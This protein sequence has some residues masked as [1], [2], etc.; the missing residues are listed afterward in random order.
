[1][2]F[3][4]VLVNEINKNFFDLFNNK[5]EINELINLNSFTP[6]KNKFL[7]ISKNLTKDNENILLVGTNSCESTFDWV[8]IGASLGKSLK[9]DASLNFVDMTSNSNLESLEFGF[10]LSQYQFDKFKS[11][12]DDKNILSIEETQFTQEIKDKIDAIFWTRDMVNTPALTKSPEFFED[13]VKKLIEETDIKLTSYDHVWLS[14]NNFGGILGVGSGS[15]RKP[16]FLIGEYNQKAKFQISIIGKGVLFDSGGLSLKS[17]AGMETMK[18]DMAGAATAWGIIT[19]VAKQKL[20]I[21]LKVYTPLV[22]NMPSGSAIRPGDVLTMR[23]NKT[24]EV[25]NTDAEGRLIMADALAYASEFKPDVICDVATLTGASYVALGVDIGAI[26]SNDKALEESF[27]ESNELSH[28][29][30]HV[31]PLEQ[32]YKKL[33]KSDIADMQNTG[34]RFGGA[35]TAAL[36]LEEFVE[37][38]PWIHLDMAG[39]ARSRNNDVITPSGGTGFGVVGFYNFIKSKATDLQ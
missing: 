37:G 23:N 31:L 8:S 36:L 4:V 35:I 3:K 27:M 6:E 32:S 15:F 22:E 11:E 20:D 28:E 26:F 17:P 29:L 14:E 39:P 38:I 5:D 2:N 10:Y 18:T 19:L 25:L 7:K 21:G 1:M 12:K 16:K 34:G 24:I 13:N 9:Y 33:I 30:Y